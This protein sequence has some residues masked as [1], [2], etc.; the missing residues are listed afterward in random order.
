MK[1]IITENKLRSVFDRYMDQYTFEIHSQGEGEDMTV[2][3]ENGD[4]VFDTFDENLVV[5]PKLW[6]KLEGLFGENFEPYLVD[7][8]NKSFDGNVETAEI[9]WDTYNFEYGDNDD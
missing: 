8:F 2:F 3:I 6:E 7:W 4:R 1:Y 5:N 9:S